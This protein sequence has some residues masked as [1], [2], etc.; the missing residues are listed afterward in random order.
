MR[1][2]D[3]LQLAICPILLGSGKPFFSGITQRVH[4][5]LQEYKKL[6]FRISIPYLRHH[7]III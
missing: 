2:V 1:L 6:L 7:K 3:E 4:L 5:K